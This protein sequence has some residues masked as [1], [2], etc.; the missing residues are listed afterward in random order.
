M[1]KN[2]IQIVHCADI[3]LDAPLRSN[4]INRQTLRDNFE[5]ICKYAD[6]QQVDLLLVCGDLV[7]N[8]FVS[9][10]TAVFL[11]ELIKK[12]SRIHFVFCSGN[13]DCYVQGSV[14]DRLNFKNVTLFLKEEIESVEI[15]ELNTVIYGFG[16]VNPHSSQRFLKNFKVKDSEKI[17]IILFHGDVIE[18][19]GSSEY[20]PLTKKDIEN[21]GCDYIALGHIHKFSGINR[22]GK[23]YYAYSGTSQG[24]GFDEI[25]EKGVIS[26]TI[27]KESNKLELIPVSKIKFEVLNCDITG[28]ENN[29]SIKE[30]ILQETL[31]FKADAVRIILSGELSDKNIINI[32]NLQQSLKEEFYY[33]EIQDNTIIKID[34]DLLKQ[35]NTLTGFF[36]KELMN[37]DLPSDRLDKAIK[38]G[39]SVL[40]E[41]GGVEIE[42]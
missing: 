38:T 8:D 42:D 34:I 10:E 40:S 7:E 28:C 1:N 37:K 3:H 21:I 19:G 22:V 27:S 5:A 20:Y 30:K 4:I 29:F 32:K 12:Y 31:S 39:I 26:G 14:Y 18:E 36:I 13:H 35:Q 33:L 23:S 11:E 17:N 15:P 2:Q 16:A 9:N 24:K 6:E 41:D 25:G